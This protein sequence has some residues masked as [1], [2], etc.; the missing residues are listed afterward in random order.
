MAYTPKTAAEKAA[1][2]AA[3]KDRAAAMGL[4][5]LTGSDKQIEWALVLR[6]EA[7]TKAEDA[8]DEAIDN[9]SDDELTDAV[10][11]IKAAREALR[12]QTKASFW[13]DHRDEGLWII[14]TAKRTAEFKTLLATAL[15][16][17]VPTTR[18]DIMKERQ[19]EFFKR[20][21]KKVIDATTMENFL[22]ASH[23]CMAEIHRAGIV[24]S[25]PDLN[26]MRRSTKL[27][28]MVRALIAEA[29]EAEDAE[30]IE[31]LVKGF[32]KET[33]IDVAEVA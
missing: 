16:E 30:G 31:Q 28:D 8:F 3:A 21:L 12:A 9:S 14:D 2:T 11:E 6:D 33:G 18:G 20:F 4:P 23:D 22:K 13:I 5:E 19:S 7:L 32:C 15:E 1:E 10:A 17:A 24:F 25:D 27:R 26:S 29:K